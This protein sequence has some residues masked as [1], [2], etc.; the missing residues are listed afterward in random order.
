MSEEQIRL[1]SDIFPVRNK[2]ENIKMLNDNRICCSAYVK[3]GTS[4]ERRTN[5]EGI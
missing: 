3:S 1:N 4:F 5:V 2:K